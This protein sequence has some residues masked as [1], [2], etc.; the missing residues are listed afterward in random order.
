MLAALVFACA[1]RLPPPSERLRRGRNT[2]GQLGT[3]DSDDRLDGSGLDLV[4]VDLDGSVATSI[5][6][7]EGHVCALLDDASV[8]CW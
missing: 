6:G 2:W 5:A 1:V 4:A 8:K 7:G 3:G